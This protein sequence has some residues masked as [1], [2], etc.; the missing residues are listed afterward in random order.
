[1]NVSSDD[2]WPST[3]A[4]Y[5]RHNDEALLK[6]SERLLATYREEL[7]PCASFEEFCDVTG[8]W[9]CQFEVY[10]SSL[11]RQFLILCV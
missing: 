2:Q 3:L 6:A 8:M 11:Y 1:V 9:K 7:L 5:I 10:I 4:D